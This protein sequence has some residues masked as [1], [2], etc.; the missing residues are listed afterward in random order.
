MRQRGNN[1]EAAPEGP[2]ASSGRHR[3]I[4][5]YT[6]AVGSARG[7][8]AP[9]SWAG[10]PLGRHHLGLP[11]ATVVE[12][13]AKLLELQSRPMSSRINNMASVV[14]NPRA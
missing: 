6:A 8:P 2:L 12:I 14:A 7:A 11:V 5:A 9:F 13:A 4:T 3:P 1:G 10:A